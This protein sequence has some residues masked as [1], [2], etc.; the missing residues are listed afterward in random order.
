MS[1]VRIRRSR[2][3]TC[4]ISNIV[5]AKGARVSNRALV[6]PGESTPDTRIRPV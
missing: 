4:S 2:I 6:I 5:T 3:T 1:A